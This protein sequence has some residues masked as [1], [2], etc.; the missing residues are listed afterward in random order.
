MTINTH[1]HQTHFLGTHHNTAAHAT[2]TL[3]S[4]GSATLISGGAYAGGEAIRQAA[5]RMGFTPAQQQAAVDFFQSGYS[6]ASGVA[7]T[8]SSELQTAAYRNGGL[9]QSVQNLS[10]NM[11]KMIDAVGAQNQKQQADGSGGSSGGGGSW[12][13]AI[14][15]AMG[16]ALGQMAS[17]LTSESQQLQSLG[18]DGSAAGAQQFQSVMA[19]FQAHSQLFSMLSDAFSTAI[20][21]IGQGMQTMASK[22]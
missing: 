16:S 19:Q 3:H 9:A 11:A 22:S 13:E 10:D 20:K 6:A 2:N 18:G 7:A 14:A 21:S 1:A 4:P 17:R 8:A 12:L 5:A 15:K